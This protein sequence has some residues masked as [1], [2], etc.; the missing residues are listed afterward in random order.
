VTNCPVST[1]DPGVS[2]VE[3]D[4]FTLVEEDDVAFTL[5]LCR[6]IHRLYGSYED[7]ELPADEQVWAGLDLTR[8]MVLTLQSSVTSGMP[9]MRL[10]VASAQVREMLAVLFGVEPG[11]ERSGLKGAI[12]EIRLDQPELTEGASPVPAAVPAALT[13]P[14]AP[15][16][17][18]PD[19]TAAR[20]AGDEIAAH[21]SRTMALWHGLPVVAQFVTGILLCFVAGALL[22]VPIAIMALFPNHLTIIGI[23]YAAIGLRAW[24]WHPSRFM[25]WARAGRPRAGWGEPSRAAPAV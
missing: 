10:R 19:S 17:P 6:E 13:A 24:Q 7:S 22:N 23:V 18:A 3:D 11:P 15:A 5:A 21:Q 14:A 16:S 1:I 8:Q 4:G 2:V 25:P 20:V 12:Q 9:S